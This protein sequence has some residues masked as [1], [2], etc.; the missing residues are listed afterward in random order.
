[1]NINEWLAAYAER[2]GTE[3]PTTEELKTI[4]DVAGAAARGSERLAAPAACWVSAKS[5]RSLAESLEVAR[6]IG[7][8]GDARD[9]P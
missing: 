9:R 8:P 1:M 5:G 3:P 6:E 7:E 4:L 2:L